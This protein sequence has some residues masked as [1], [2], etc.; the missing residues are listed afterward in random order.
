M[1]GAS[2]LAIAA[3]GALVAPVAMSATFTSAPTRPVEV[4]LTHIDPAL[5]PSPR[6]PTMSRDLASRPRGITAL[7]GADANDQP[8]SVSAW[9][10][11]G[12]AAMH[13]RSVQRQRLGTIDYS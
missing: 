10:M 2:I 3:A 13:R 12:C 4:P 1:L 9:S 7:L 5:D 6:L 11:T 8:A